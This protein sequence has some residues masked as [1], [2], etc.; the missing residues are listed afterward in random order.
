MKTIIQIKFRFFTFIF[1]ID[2]ILYLYV[3]CMYLTS[4]TYC[5]QEDGWVVC[6]L[7]K[8][9]IHQRELHQDH[10]M[11]DDLQFN[12]HMK[13]SNNN[14]TSQLDPNFD[15]Q[16]PWDYTMENSMQLPQLLSTESAAT[17][18]FNPSNSLNVTDIECSQNLIKLMGAA[19][20]ESSGS[21]GLL[22]HERLNGDWSILDKLLAS[23]QNLDQL[24]HGRGGG[25]QSQQVMNTG[26]EAVSSTHKFPFQY[27]GCEGGGKC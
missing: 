27:L 15:H 13:T 21:L 20:G 10:A 22:Q 16:I 1:N 5:M 6:R 12:H 9:K 14:D 26:A 11:E 24:I 25:V 19:G 18:P 17:F 7:F 8:K 23:H 3:T 4:T 2:P